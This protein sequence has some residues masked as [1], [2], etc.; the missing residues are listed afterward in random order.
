MQSYNVVNYND[1]VMDGFYDV[2]GITSNSVVQVQGKMP[3]LMDLQ[4]VSILDNI[5]YEVV[6]VNRFVD[7][8]LQELEKKAYI[9]SLE[10]RMSDG[11]HL[12]GLIQKLADLVVDRMGGPVGDAD[13]ISARWTRRSHE[14]RNAL[15]S[16]ILPLGRLDVGLSRH[17]AL[18]FKVVKSLSNS[19]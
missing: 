12:S 9:M 3:L 1:K 17:R 11:F 18:L 13:E 5:D 15:N 6:L 19:W 7:P 8:E 16:I 4:A 2:Y 14:L 10:S